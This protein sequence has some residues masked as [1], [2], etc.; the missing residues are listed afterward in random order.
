MKDYILN[1]DN[2]RPLKFSG[3]LLGSSADKTIAE[4]EESLDFP[5]IQS[6]AQLVLE[7]YRTKSG[8]IILAEYRVWA[9]L[10]MDDL[11]TGHNLSVTVFDSLEDYSK[12]LEE[13]FGK[14]SAKLI[15]N[16]L[17]NYP[18]VEE[19]LVEKID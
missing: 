16:V 12:T 10:N 6:S 1:A 8:K 15:K 17:R 4:F 9:A 14:L 11:A 13:K 5:D 18:D 19:H 7:L 2:R 3:E